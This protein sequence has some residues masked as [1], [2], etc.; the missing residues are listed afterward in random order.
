[1]QNTPLSNRLHVGIFGR[2]NVGKSTLINALTGQD[3]AIVSDIPGTTTDPVYKAMEVHGLGPLVLIDTGGIDD[4]GVIGSMRVKKA[5]W[6]LNKS[7]IN[8]LVIDKEAGI[9]E[10]EERFLEEVKKRGTPAVVVINKADISSKNGELA[11]WLADRKTPFVEI[12]ALKKTGINNLREKIREA[13]PDDF[14]RKIIL[15]DLLS[16][17]DMVLIVA[18]LDIEAPKGRLKLPQVQ[19][20]RDTL[21]TD[22]ATM[23]L[24]EDALEAALANLKKKPRLVITESQVFDT[25]AK[26]LPD[27]VPLTSFSILYARYKGNFEALVT[28]AKT[29]DG[30]TADSPILIAEACTHHPIGEDIARVVIPDLLKRRLKCAAEDLHIDYA[31]GYDFPEDL[32]GYKLV[33]HC[34]GCMLNRREMIYRINA[35]QKAGVAVTNYGIFIAYCHGILERSLK[36]FEIK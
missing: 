11:A 25:V 32:N 24:K 7:D 29:I 15:R 26:I 20:I 18:P 9:T 4:E 16:K 34:G 28:G 36:I 14:E 31:A 23:I 21:D 30:L 17:H 2:R 10:H 12:S 13:A 5:F 19:T 35:A 27:D 6:I 8:L 1:M 22:C 33:I 3:I